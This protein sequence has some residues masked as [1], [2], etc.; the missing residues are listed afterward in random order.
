[1]ASCGWGPVSIHGI[2]LTLKAT[3]GAAAGPFPCVD[4][5]VLLN[6]L[7]RCAFETN[8]RRD[9]KFVLVEGFKV[10]KMKRFVAESSSLF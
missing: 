10:S 8:S 6:E 2:A 5:T 3:D 4:V 9:F 7:T 1:M